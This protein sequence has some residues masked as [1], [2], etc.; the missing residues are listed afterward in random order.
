M[1]L[2]QLLALAAL[3][4]EFMQAYGREFGICFVCGRQLEN[5][6]SVAMGIGPICRER[7]N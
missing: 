2:A 7:F 3:K 6:E 4:M 1:V 5:E